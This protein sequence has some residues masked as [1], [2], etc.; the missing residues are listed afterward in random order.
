ML[1][2]NFTFKIFSLYLF[3]YHKNKLQYM[4]KAEIIIVSYIK[5]LSYEYF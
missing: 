4:A 3:F 1:I 5:V 2:I